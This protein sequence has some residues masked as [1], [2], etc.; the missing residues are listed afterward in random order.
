MKFP[1]WHWHIENSSICSLRC[2]RCPRQE[3]PDSL[4]QTSLGLEF[5]RRNFS[6]EF[7]RE[8]WEITFCGDDGDPIYGK[9]FLDIVM[10]LK[11]TKPNLSLRIVTNG[12]YKNKDWWF[13]LGR[14]LNQYDEIHFSID[15]W[16]QE[17][18]AQYRVNSNWEST[19]VGI[20]VLRENTTAIMY[21][22]MIYFS[23]NEGYGEDQMLVLADELGFDKFQKTQSTK[24]GSVQEHY[25]QNGI[26][27]L[28]PTSVEI[29]DGRFKREIIN[30]TERTQYLAY[31]KGKLI[32]DYYTQVKEEFGNKFVP[33]CKIGTKGLY[34]T[35]SGHFAPCCWVANR[36]EH[37]MWGFFKQDHFDLNK[38][39]MY[40]ILNDPYW[41]TYYSNLDKNWECA[42]KCAN[43]KIESVSKW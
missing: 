23:F 40:D 26:D 35:A 38:R 37:N 43:V 22:D 7:L 25:K 1:I 8:V 29:T 20:K 41:I 14:T 9:D 31:D 19:M 2:P 18:N 39:S 24:V 30:L 4:V 6:K 3:V 33:L 36:Y 12:S 28:E 27:H 10:Y 13:L 15:G 42:N 32:M 11:R 34:I 21:W 17:S 16:D 5:F